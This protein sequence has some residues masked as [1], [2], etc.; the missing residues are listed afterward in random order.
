MNLSL[1]C[2]L[3]TFVLTS[4]QMFPTKFRLRE[5]CHFI[6]DNVSFS[7]LSRT[8]GLTAV[9][10]RGRK[11]TNVTKRDGN[12]TL[13]H[14]LVCEHFWL[15]HSQIY[16]CLTMKETNPMIPRCFMMSSNYIFCFHCFHRAPSSGRNY[17]AVIITLCHAP[18]RLIQTQ[19]VFFSVCNTPGSRWM[20][21]WIHLCHY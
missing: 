12:Q 11:S 20:S 18:W 21:L 5:I 8:S 16:I 3:L 17:E 13:I 9:R 6:Q 19:K 15:S 10:E 2:M 1:F 7:L 4:S 14:D